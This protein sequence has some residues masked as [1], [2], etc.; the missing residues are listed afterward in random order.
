MFVCFLIKIT[1]DKILNCIVYRS[2]EEYDRRRDHRRGS[3]DGG[4]AGVGGSGGAAGVPGQP[5]E[6]G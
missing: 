5:R 6:G 1:L 4:E 2:V 3:F